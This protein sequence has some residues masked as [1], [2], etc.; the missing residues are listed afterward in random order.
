MTLLKQPNIL[1]ADD[2]P[3]DQDLLIEALL[4]Q[5][6]DVIVKS[7]WNGQEVLTYLTACP[8]MDLP[9]LLLLDFKMPIL[10]AVEV[11]EQLREDARYRSIPKVVWSTSNRPEYIN[12]CLEMGAS[13]YFT[14]PNNPKE[15]SN[16]TDKVLSLFAGGQV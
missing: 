3:E 1:V 4:Q 9:S 14:K 2:D 10:N 13:L 6:P 16:M 11:L 7:V 8:D 15:L 12:S 5:S